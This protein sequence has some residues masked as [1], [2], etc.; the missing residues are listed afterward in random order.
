MQEVSGEFL[1]LGEVN[2]APKRKGLAAR[3]LPQLCLN[4]AFGFDENGF[5][6][7]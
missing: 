5:V 7:Y 1:K 3:F 4:Y 6:P 2:C